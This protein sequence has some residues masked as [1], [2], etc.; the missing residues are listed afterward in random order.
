[1][2]LP[3][4]I[5]DFY[6]KEKAWAVLTVAVIVLLSFLMFQREKDDSSVSSQALQQ[7]KTAESR[8]KQEI[9]EAGGIQKLL[10]DEPQL[11]WGFSFFSSFLLASFLLGIVMNFLWWSRPAW[12]Q[13]FW[14]GAGPPEA[15]HWSNSTVFKVVLLF[16]LGSVS[17]SFFLALLKSTLFREV[18]PNLLVLI[19][20]TLS[21]I[22]CV[23]LVVGFIRAQGGSWQELGFREIRPVRDSVIGVAG[24]AA[25]LPFFL[26]VLFA[27]IV[28]IQIFQYEPPA[29]PLLEVFLEEEK[30]PKTISYSILL[31]CVAG[32]ILEEIFFRGFCYPAFKKRWGK[33][34]GMVLSAAFFSGIHQNLFAFFPVM[35]LGIGLAYLYEKRGSLFPSI[36]LHIVHNAVFISYFFLTKKILQLT[37]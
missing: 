29:H 23:G 21:D 19:H 20:T 4:D 3:G 6:R 24:Y 9:N 7:L 31:A 25:V 32:P 5:L 1:M 30:A 15:R 33:A 11:L 26:L 36:I 34:W 2:K 37:L 13:S 16:I 28:L 17:L 14:V 35:V 27:L 10:E 8:L 22:L 12:R 18:S